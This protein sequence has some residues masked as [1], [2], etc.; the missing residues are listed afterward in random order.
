MLSFSL[1]LNFSTVN[2]HEL[3]IEQDD[4]KDLISISDKDGSKVEIPRI[5]VVSDLHFY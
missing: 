1:I 5:K 2:C 4:L 3:E